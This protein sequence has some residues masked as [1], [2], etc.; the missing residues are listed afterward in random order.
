MCVCVS[1]SPPRSRRKQVG[2]HCK[3]LKSGSDAGSPGWAVKA[4]P[5]DVSARHS[6]G[7][8]G[9]WFGERRGRALEWFG[10][11]LLFSRFQV[12]VKMVYLNEILGRFCF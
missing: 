12:F 8:P 4:H 3:A 9:L 5:W 6:L 11:R 2:L 1:V 10:R 7:A